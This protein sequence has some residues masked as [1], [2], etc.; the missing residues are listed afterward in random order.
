M[1]NRQIPFGLLQLF[2]LMGG[3]SASPLSEP[4]GENEERACLPCTEP[5]CSHPFIKEPNCI[6]FRKCQLGCGCKFG[7]IRHDLNNRCI[8]AVECKIPKHQ[9]KVPIW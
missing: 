1:L 2:L 5:K 4:C 9:L 7:Y 6:F 3:F 8:P